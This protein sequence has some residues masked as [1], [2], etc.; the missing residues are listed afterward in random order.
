MSSINEKLGL[1]RAGKRSMMT[2]LPK[3]KIDAAKIT[4]AHCPSCDRTGARLS[5]TAPGS[6]YCP[7]CNTIW[8]PK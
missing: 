5:R 8:E 7:W 6:L 3:N 4:S 1:K 2:G